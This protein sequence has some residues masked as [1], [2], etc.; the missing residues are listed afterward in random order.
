[1]HI[2]FDNL[3]GTH[4]YRV[5]TYIDGIKIEYFEKCINDLYLSVNNDVFERNWT[6][7]S[8]LVTSKI[9]DDLD[10]ELKKLQQYTIKK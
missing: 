10:G 5:I 9:I 1:M 8:I 2:I 3:E 4:I 7:H 6:W